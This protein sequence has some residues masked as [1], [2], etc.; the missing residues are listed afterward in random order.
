MKGSLS[1]K[2]P[3][4]RRN[5]WRLLLWGAFLLAIFFGGFG[6]S[7]GCWGKE[8]EEES[9]ITAQPISPQVEQITTSNGVDFALRQKFDLGLF[10]VEQAK[11]Q[12]ISQSLFSQ[13]FIAIKIPHLQGVV[14]HIVQDEAHSPQILLTDYPTPGSER[15][16]PLA[17]RSDYIASINAILPIPEG[18][19]AHWEVLAPTEKLTLDCSHEYWEGQLMFTIRYEGAVSSQ[20]HLLEIALCSNGPVQGF[21]FYLQGW[22][23]CFARYWAILGA[24]DPTSRPLNIRSQLTEWVSAG[25]EQNLWHEVENLST[26]TRTVTFDYHSSLG[27]DWAFFTSWRGGEPITTL[28][29]G[30]G[31]TQTFYARTQLPEEIEG[32]ETLLITV[33]DQLDPSAY[34]TAFDNL[35]IAKDW[36]QEIQVRLLDL[37]LIRK[38]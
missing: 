12:K 32:I 16:I 28:T 26:I 22:T 35:T 5:T 6:C 18:E 21:P 29:L 14:G 8:G 4:R 20:G 24:Q 23:H 7:H 38:Q 31:E 34:D 9:S 2:R 33:T 17:R 1:P 19:Q 36:T 27:L 13:G 3:S 37:P 30:P 25:E 10:E 15:T 11:C